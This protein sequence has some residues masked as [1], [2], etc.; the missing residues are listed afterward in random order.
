MATYRVII[1]SMSAVY[2]ERWEADSPYEAEQKARQR[3]QR[4][5]GD[6]GAFR[7]YAKQI[8]PTRWSDEDES[9]D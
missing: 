7:F 2:R 8:T 3:W 4:E 5:F 6:A 9:D 1:N